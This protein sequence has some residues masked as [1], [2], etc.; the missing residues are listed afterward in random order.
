MD[1]KKKVTVFRTEVSSFLFSKKRLLAVC[2][3]P[4][5]SA[6]HEGERT[7]LHPDGMEI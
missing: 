6:L 4:E 2:N 3:G 7:D 5:L 1:R